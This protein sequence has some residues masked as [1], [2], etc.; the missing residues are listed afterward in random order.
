MSDDFRLNINLM[1]EAGDT[2]QDSLRVEKVIKRKT[3]I[4]PS[5][6]Y[7]INAKTK[8]HATK[9]TNKLNDETRRSY[10]R[11][12]EAAE[13][14]A[15]HGYE[16]EQNPIVEGTTRKPD[17]IIEKE[18]FDCYSPSKATKVRSISS[19]IEEKVIIKKQTNRVVLNL[20][21]WNGN[22]EEL[23]KELNDYPIE[24]LKEVLI[25]KNREVHSIYP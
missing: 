2:L 8:G 11:E 25:V 20:N 12:N 22:I 17:Y 15:Q 9:I 14:I 10:L 4:S 13:V 5:K 23:I 16:M 19:T 7:N 24:G 21:D 3:K 1:D 6:S 18:I